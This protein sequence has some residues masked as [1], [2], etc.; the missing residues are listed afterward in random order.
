MYLL[1]ALSPETISDI[2]KLDNCDLFP[3]SEFKMHQA[4]T[5]LLAIFTPAWPRSPLR[6]PEPATT[7]YTSTIWVRQ[8]CM[9]LPKLN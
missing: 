8:T 1:L 6:F 7:G 3:V 2:L 4:G 5:A 9:L